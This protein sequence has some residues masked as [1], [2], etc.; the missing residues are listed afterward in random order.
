M[1]DS[2]AWVEAFTKI[3]DTPPVWGRSSY[4]SFSYPP[5]TNYSQVLPLQPE[6]PTT[7][8]TR[9]LVNATPEFQG[10]RAADVYREGA[11]G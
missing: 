6:P 4:F 7:T 2:E 8:I 1:F 5:H 3:R 10:D 11:I 9:W